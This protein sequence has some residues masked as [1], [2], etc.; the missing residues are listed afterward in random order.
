MQDLSTKRIFLVG[1][2]G[3]GCEILKNLLL[4]GVKHIAV[5]DLDVIDL[6]NLNRQ[7]LFSREH[8][9]KP[10]ATT[11]AEVA[12][13]RY[14]P[15]AVVE[16]FHTDVQ[17]ERFS[18]AF[19]QSFDLVINALDNLDA[20]KHVNRMCV[21][22]Q[23]PLI[24]GGTS[25]FVGQA[26]PI[27]PRETE[28]YMCEPKAAPKGY[29]VCTIRS[30]P[31]T[32]VHCIFWS[33]QLFQRLFGPSDKDNVL[34]DL[35]F[36]GAGRDWRA[37]FD[38]VFTQDIVDLRK[39]DD[40]WRLRKKPELW[41]FEEMAAGAAPGLAEWCATFE[42]AFG[43][44]RGRAE[45]AGPMPFDKDDDDAVDFVFA[46]TNIRCTIFHIAPLGR[47]DVQAKAGN[48]I[49]A[50]PTTNAIISGLMTVEAVKV[51][52]GV[53]PLTTVYLSKKPVN[54]KLLRFEQTPAPNPECYVCGTIRVTRECD[55]KVTTLKELVDEVTQTASLVNPSVMADGSLL[56]EIDDALEDDERA[57]YDANGAKTLA[58][59]GMRDGSV[60]DLKDDLKTVSLILRDMLVLRRLTCSSDRTH[61]LDTSDVSPAASHTQHE[62]KR[63][64]N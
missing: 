30:N 48:I 52:R 39:A 15:D 40:L 31:T 19:Y 18:I 13:R 21:C 1:A 58:Q 43:R 14:A 54:Q 9:G 49:P 47:F 5:V 57:M 27:V 36:D 62:A 20:R 26:T 59:L 37:V 38:K 25:G 29:A 34:S 10:K 45:A 17:D 28:C 55:L 11:A 24:D 63:P 4:S 12:V 6:S 42:R 35:Q 33:K 23:V 61:P 46:A 56:M 53:R 50:I 16:A 60:V 64:S 22:A 7:F 3:I 8:I 41:T 32:S 51:L 44:L 2:G